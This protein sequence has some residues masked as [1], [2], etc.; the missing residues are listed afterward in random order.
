M[1]PIFFK[2]LIIKELGQY[3]IF[4]KTNNTFNTNNAFKKTILIG[5]WLYSEGDYLNE[6]VCLELIKSDIWF[7]TLWIVALILLN[8]QYR[9]EVKA[10]FIVVVPLVEKSSTLMWEKG[11]LW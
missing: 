6:R 10:V 4:N 11:Y 8:Q 3:N 1:G 5:E 9:G 2:A 7:N